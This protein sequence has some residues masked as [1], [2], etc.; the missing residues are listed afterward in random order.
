MVATA[1]HAAREFGVRSGMPL[2]TATK[3]C[4]DAVCLPAD[5][6]AYEGPR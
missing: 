5:N 6:P 4:P 1:S 2:R 3:R